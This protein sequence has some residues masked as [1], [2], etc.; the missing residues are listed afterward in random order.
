MAEELS[1]SLLLSTDSSR[2]CS[3]SLAILQEEL[4]ESL[5][6]TYAPNPLCRCTKSDSSPSCR[7]ARSALG[8][9]SYSFCTALC[10]SPVREEM[11]KGQQIRLHSQHKLDRRLSSP[12]LRR[13][14]RYLSKQSSVWLRVFMKYS[15]SSVSL[16]SPLVTQSAQRGE[17]KDNQ[18]SRFSRDRINNCDRVSGLLVKLHK[19]THQLLLSVQHQTKLME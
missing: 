8:M 18:I 12:N 2:G 9:C 19:R 1:H 4:H 7:T 5:L 14:C 13:T 11:E 15:M 16:C 3:F 10:G 6:P 17:A